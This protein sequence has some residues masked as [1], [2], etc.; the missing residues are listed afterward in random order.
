MSVRETA[1]VLGCCAATVYEMHRRGDMERMGVRV[2]SLG[3][4]LRVVTADLRRVVGV[5][6]SGGPAKTA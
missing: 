5:E 1:R 4:A 2:L 6:A 3:R